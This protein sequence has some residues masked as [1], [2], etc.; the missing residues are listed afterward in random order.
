M[1]AGIAARAGAEGAAPPA[2]PG[3]FFGAVNHVCHFFTDFDF[4]APEGPNTPIISTIQFYSPVDSDQGKAKAQRDWI[5]RA[6]MTP[7]TLHF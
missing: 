6:R 5:R 1:L 3:S 4:L 2:I 7:T